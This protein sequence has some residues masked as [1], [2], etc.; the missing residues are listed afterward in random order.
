MR[1][2]NENTITDAALGQMA[3]TTSPRFKQIMS[4]LVKHLHEFTREKDAMS[5]P[6]GADPAQIISKAAH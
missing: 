5:G 4:S 6:V 1:V 3:G 2:I